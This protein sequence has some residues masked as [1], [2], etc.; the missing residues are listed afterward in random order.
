MSNITGVGLFL[1]IF[2]VSFYLSYPSLTHCRVARRNIKQGDDHHLNFPQWNVHK[3]KNS[4]VHSLLPKTLTHAILSNSHFSEKNIKY[5]T[6]AN[7][8]RSERT[9]FERLSMSL[10]WDEVGW[11]RTIPNF[12]DMMSLFSIWLKGWSEPIFLFDLREIRRW[13]DPITCLDGRME[14]G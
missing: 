6:Q 5:G 11:V 9:L 12:W 8:H 1:F 14:V 3:E 13:N 2:V 10:V 7:K 4:V